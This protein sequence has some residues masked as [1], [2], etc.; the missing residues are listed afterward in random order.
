LHFLAETSLGKR[1]DALDVD[2]AEHGDDAVDLLAAALVLPHALAD[3]VERAGV[4]F[5]VVLQLAR[6]G[7]RA[8]SVHRRHLF[9]PC[10]CRGIRGCTRGEQMRAA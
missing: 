9:K 6:F 4:R 2:L 5:A 3:L 7:V 1:L 8:G 10:R